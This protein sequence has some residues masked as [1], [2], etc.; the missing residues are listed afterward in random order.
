MSNWVIVLLWVHDGGDG[1]VRQELQ[2]VEWYG[3]GERGWVGDIEGAETLGLIDVLRTCG[4]GWV[5]LLGALDLHTL[6]DNY[7]M[8]ALYLT[9]VYIKFVPSNGFIKASLAMVAQA[10]LV[11]EASG[12][13]TP[14]WFPPITC[15]T[16]SYVAK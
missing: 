4:H 16:A 7:R 15:L 12:W 3:H 11:A 8:L 2:R 10:P 5:E 1:L 9:I 6:L 13:C 14:A